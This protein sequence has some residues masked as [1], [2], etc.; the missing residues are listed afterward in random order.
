MG[1]EPR[2]LGQP[3]TAADKSPCLG[4]YEFNNEN[5]NLSPNNT[6]ERSWLVPEII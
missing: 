5:I 2:T 6:K 4:L 3:C 1:E